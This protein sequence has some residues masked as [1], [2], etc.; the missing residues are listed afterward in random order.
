MRKQ[1]LICLGATILGWAQPLMAQSYNPLY[2]GALLPEATASADSVPS[3][4]PL[5]PAQPRTAPSTTVAGSTMAGSALPAMPDG[6]PVGQALPPEP[7]L[8]QT[9]ARNAPLF[10]YGQN[11][12]SDVFGA[13]LFSGAFGR[14]GAAQFNPDYV[15]GVGDRVLIRMWG[16]FTFSQVL[17]VDPQ[18]N[19]FLPNVGPVR[20]LGARNENLQAIVERAAGRA[21]RNNVYTYASLAEAQP[22]RIY[23]GGFVNRPGLYEGTSMDNLLHYL[24]L[25]GGIDTLRGS[26]LT[27]QVKRGEQVRREVNLYDFLL[28]GV[29]PLVQLSDGDVIFVGPRQNTVTVKG[30]AENAKIFE[31]KRGVL[32]TTEDL[33]AMARPLASATHMRIARNTGPVRNVEYYP[34]SEAAKLWV[35]NGDEI[36]FTADKKQG[37]ITVRVEGEHDSAQEYVLP[38]GAHLGDL[39][40]QISFSERSNTSSIQLYRKSVKVRQKEMLATSLRSLET[41]ALTARSGTTDEARLRAQEAELILR[42]IDRAKAIEPVGQVVLAKGPARDNLLLESGDVLRV[43][44]R[45]DLVLISGEVLFPNAVAA[46]PGLSVDEYIGRAGGYTQNNGGKR[47]IVA[48]Q[49]GSYNEL[50]GGDRSVA[51]GDEL[52]VLPKMDTKSRQIFKDLTQI[53]Y[54]IAVSARVVLGL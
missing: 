2:P 51:A 15:V 26:F 34:L 45:D 3:G 7:A 1:S 40:Q 30:L 25:A 52:L 49:D 43:P 20:L 18:G 36:E 41:A 27:V 24:D 14:T 48:H 38:H 44:V 4:S 28:N 16:A 8:P 31:F 17:T 13:T 50:R 53:L 46:Q 33:I 47:I 54:Q 42:W 39:L 22:V 9:V 5:D 23:V 32:T 19:V 6:A 37:T 10:D 35:Q 21:F 11:V 29:M 12:R